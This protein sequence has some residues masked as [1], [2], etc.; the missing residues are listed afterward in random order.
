M[1]FSCQQVR[2][3][4]ISRG[5]MLDAGYPDD[6]PAVRSLTEV[7]D[8]YRI[9]VGLATYLSEMLGDMERCVMQMCHLVWPDGR[10]VLGQGLPKSQRRQRCY[11]WLVWNGADMPYK[12]EA[13]LGGGHVAVRYL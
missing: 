10:R 12:V 4:V 2:K 3:L 5:T 11:T 13:Y 8:E 9:Q 6:D 7:R 1:T